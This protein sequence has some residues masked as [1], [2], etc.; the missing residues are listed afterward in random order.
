V[1]KV[2]S[3]QTVLAE[4][5]L[6]AAF[7]GAGFEQ[8]AISPQV[9]HGLQHDVGEEGVSH[10]MKNANAPFFVATQGSVD[11]KG[12]A[13]VLGFFSSVP[14]PHGSEARLGAFKNFRVAEQ[15][16]GK[17]VSEVFGGCSGGQLLTHILIGVGFDAFGR[18]LRND[19]FKALKL[20]VAI[21]QSMNAAV[22]GLLANEALNFSGKLLAHGGV[23]LFG[24]FAHGVDEKLL[25][26]REA[27]RER[28]EEG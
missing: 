13:A 24:T 23:H 15:P 25:A 6:V 18:T 1:A 21:E 22:R 5:E 12:R 19:I 27:H 4:Q 26:N 11:V 2:T 7:P 17:D 8:A 9:V 10:I 28:I 3:Q 20:N 14:L 16:I